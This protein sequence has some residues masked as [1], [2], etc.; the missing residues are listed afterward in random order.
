MIIY[1]HR[2]EALLCNTCTNGMPVNKS[3]KYNYF[4]RVT[5]LLT[6]LIKQRNRNSI[7]SV[8]FYRLL[9][10]CLKR[11]ELKSVH[12]R[13][14]ANRISLLALNSQ[15]HWW[16]IANFGNLCRFLKLDQLTKNFFEKLY[17]TKKSHNFFLKTIL[18][19]YL[20]TYIFKVH[21]IKRAILCAI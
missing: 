3:N 8:I 6:L 7:N 5:V 11:L 21:C 19:T 13:Y 17:T 20:K 15:S 14:L 18:K 2:G 10:Y 9:Q 16:I 12:K 1:K 4:K